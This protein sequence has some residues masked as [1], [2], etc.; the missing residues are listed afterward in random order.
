MFPLPSVTRCPPPP[1]IGHGK[2]RVQ[3]L[4]EFTSGTSVIYHCE[5]GYS[6]LGEASLHCTAS[7]AWSH[8]L[9]QCEVTCVSPAV[10][11]GRTNGVQLAY[12]PRD[13]V[14]FECDPGYNLSGSPQAQCQ[15]DGSWDP[16]IP[17][18]ERILQCLSPPPIDHGKPSA[19]ALA[20]FT[21]GMSVN[22]SCEIGYWLTGPASVYCTAA[23]TWSPLPPR[24]TGSYNFLSEVLGIIGGVL[25]L[26]VVII[27]IWKIVSKQNTG[28]YY[29]HENNK[30]HEPLTHVTEQKTSFAP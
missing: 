7:G 5:P 12:R 23:G 17:I 11:N 10:D 20:V 24:C 1:A 6:L 27:I 8:P 21:S 26:L 13:V 4:D 16:P 22:Y 14:L 2:P 18:C 9:P 25:L 15:E 28:Y 29:T 30:Y 19:Q 3:A